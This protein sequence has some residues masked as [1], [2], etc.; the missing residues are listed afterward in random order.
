MK[1]INIVWLKRDL[2]TQ[3]HEPLQLAESAGLPYLILFLFE[4]EMYRYPDCSIR[5][6][7]FQY[8]S[9]LEMNRSLQPFHKSVIMLHVDAAPVFEYLLQ[10][11]NVQRVFSHRESGTQHT[12]KRDRHVS[13]IFKKHGTHWQESQQ[14]GVLRGIND[15]KGWDDRWE[16]FMYRPVIINTFSNSPA[17]NSEHPF[18]MPDDLLQT[19]ST[20]PKEFQPAG[21][22]NGK[23][24]LRSC[25]EDRGDGFSRNIS[26]PHQSRKSC[27][28]LSPYI[29]WGNLSVRQVVQQTET[30]VE[31][32]RFKGP[33]RNFLTR[34]VWHCHFIQKFETEC[35]YETSCI[36]RAYE[37]LEW[38]NRDDL[39]QA[40]MEGKT[41]VPLVD[42]CMRCLHTT[43]WINFRMR[44]LVV[45]FLCHHLLID[46][47][48]GA[49]HLARL[50]LD[51]DPGIHYPQFQMQAG[52]TGVNT[53]RIYN[54]E[55][56]SR[57]HDPDGTFIRAWVPELKELDD[58]HIHAPWLMTEM[59]Q[60][61][62]D[63]KLGEHNPQPVVDLE[64]NVKRGRDLVWSMRKT[65]CSR[66]E[67]KRIVKTHVRKGSEEVKAPKI[68][69]VKRVKESEVSKES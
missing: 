2:R 68:R 29:A 28:R 4:P 57:E 10:K 22:S 3:D 50:F 47:R 41:G 13:A 5:H 54:P 11:Y 65:D 52:T 35:G 48:K 33:Y 12:W 63:L 19:L 14:N 18:T 23:R 40:W 66:K 55:K 59:E 60:S 56:N 62:V 16:E 67:G 44:A 58:H 34:L 42:A 32:K 20:Y 64:M 9:I 17:L 53:V 24:Y 30:A 46:W 31:H 15:R 69:K 43:G 27:S 25:L 36:N 45:S 39:L 1:N 38:E 49:Y 7:Q 26:K 21:E 37:E 51:Y 8:H 61:F 6:L